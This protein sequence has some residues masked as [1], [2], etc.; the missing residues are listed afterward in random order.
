[1]TCT[2]LAAC[3]NHDRPSRLRKLPKRPRK[4]TFG[5]DRL[6]NR[7]PPRTGRPK[8]RSLA[9]TNPDKA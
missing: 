7:L 8:L 3:Y 5:S 9:L 6:A 4:N 2:G 1:M